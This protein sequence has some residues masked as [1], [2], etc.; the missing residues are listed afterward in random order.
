MHRLYQHPVTAICGQNIFMDSN[1]SRKNS[2]NQL[3][4]VLETCNS[5]RQKF[6][7]QTLFKRAAV[8]EELEC[9]DKVRCI[10]EQRTLHCLQSVTS[11]VIEKKL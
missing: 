3:S 6:Y 5:L 4:L 1:D 11:E 8:S 2:N 7:F 10:S 9:E